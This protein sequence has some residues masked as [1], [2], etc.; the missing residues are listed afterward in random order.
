MCA[1]LFKKAGLFRKPYNTQFSTKTQTR[2]PVL[3]LS[4]TATPASGPCVDS[5]LTL[6]LISKEHTER[7]SYSSEGLGTLSLSPAPSD[8]H[9]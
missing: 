9:G 7:D 4:P 2:L 5:V 8:S 6:T 1:H 3:A